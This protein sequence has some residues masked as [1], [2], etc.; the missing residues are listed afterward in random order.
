MKKLDIEGISNEASDEVD[1]NE[2]EESVLFSSRLADFLHNKAKVFAD[3][4]N[5][6]LTLNQLKKVYCH[7]ARLGEIQRT[8]DINLYALARVNM[9]LRLK[10]GDKMIQITEDSEAADSITE[11]QL[12]TQSCK[13][14]SK[15][16]DISEEWIPNAGDFTKAAE[17]IKENNLEYSYKSI[18]NLYLEY[19]PLEPNWE[20]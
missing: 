13:T 12:E 7:S 5:S 11:L 6:S 10:S 17:E 14:P 3:K 20:D 2:Q 18:N 19:E 4:N 1:M 8:D 9:F 15:F 16:I